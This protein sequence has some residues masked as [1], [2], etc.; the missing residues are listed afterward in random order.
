MENARNVIVQ[1]V[2]EFFRWLM[3]IVSFVIFVV[4]EV[5]LLY[6]LYKLFV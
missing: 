2:S 4:L 5:Y 6:A 3:P 1:L